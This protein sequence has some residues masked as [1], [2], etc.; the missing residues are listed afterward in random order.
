MTELTTGEQLALTD[1]ESQPFARVLMGLGWDKE[2]SAGF[3][4]SGAPDVDLDASA[5]AFAH[6]QYADMVFYNN[7]TTRDGAVV[8]LGD[9]Q[10][11]RGE[12]DDETIT[13][14][15][16]KVH[17]QIDTIVF[18]VSSYQGHTLEWVRNAYCRLVD[19]GGTELA[20]V[21]LTNGVPET[22]AVLAKLVRDGDHWSLHAIGQGI[23][24]K[25]PSES[26]AALLPYV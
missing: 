18:Q 22:G 20:R 1:E 15:L 7:L 24:V 11:G 5:V 10:S 9:N 4:G 12:G 25:I 19:E 16:T 3:I 2:K 8:H 26:V 14:D 17:P 13:V 6:G 21:T 23:A